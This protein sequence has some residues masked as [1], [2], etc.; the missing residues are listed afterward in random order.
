MLRLVGVVFRGQFF[1]GVFPVAFVKQRDLSGDYGVCHG[2]VGHGLRQLLPVDEGG[3][4]PAESGGAE[5]LKILVEQHSHGYRVVL[6]HGVLDAGDEFALILRHRNTAD[7]AGNKVV[8]EILVALNEEVQPG[9]INLVRLAVLG[10]AAEDQQIV[11][12][13]R[14][15]V[16]V[17]GAQVECAVGG[18]G[19]PGK[20]VPSLG[21][22]EVLLAARH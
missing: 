5:Q 8:H 3:E 16:V 15:G 21:G 22:D 1:P 13:Y 10:V 4:R 18:S 6:L 11:V 20:P 9:G 2:V 7:G 14:V 17:P 12:G 19:V